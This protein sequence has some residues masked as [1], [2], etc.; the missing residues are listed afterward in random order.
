V[1]QRKEEGL[2]LEPTKHNAGTRLGPQQYLHPLSFV[3]ELPDI[4]HSE[5]VIPSSWVP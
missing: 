4:S 1:A 3:Y 5:P 2:V